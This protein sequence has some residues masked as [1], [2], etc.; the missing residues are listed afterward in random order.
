MAKKN[1]K[2]NIDEG[3]DTKD[4]N[5]VVLDDDI[6][7]VKTKRQR[8]NEYI[9]V[10]IL[11]MDHYRTLETARSS[12]NDTTST[13]SV[14]S[15]STLEK[16]SKFFSDASNGQ[17]DSSE[18]NET[19]AKTANATA[20]WKAFFG[21]NSPKKLK[22]QKISKQPPTKTPSSTPVPAVNPLNS[23]ANQDKPLPPQRKLVEISQ[24]NDDIP[25]EQNSEPQ[26][27]SFTGIPL[28][29]RMRPT[30]MLHYT[31]YP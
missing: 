24:S 31:F 1:K 16:T 30:C 26:R 28:A 8:L 10:F 2:E 21:P 12:E 17:V 4:Q 15:T 6:P 19:G 22:Q 29:E 25:N 13:V 27:K 3:D 5:E 11:V 20:A 18:Q 23:T 14:N 7:F 9:L